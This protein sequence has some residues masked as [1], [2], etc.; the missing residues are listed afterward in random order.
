MTTLLPGATLNSFLDAESGKNPGFQENNTLTATLDPQVSPTLPPEKTILG[1]SVNTFSFVFLGIGA[2]APIIF[3]TV[4]F[5][6]MKCLSRRRLNRFKQYE[7]RMRITQEIWDL[8]R[9]QYFRSWQPRRGDIGRKVKST[10]DEI[11]FLDDS[12][13]GGY[14]YSYDQKSLGIK[15][16][17]KPLDMDNA[18]QSNSNPEVFFKEPPNIV[19][20]EKY[21]GP[22]H[23]RAFSS[24][25][26]IYATPQKANH[27]SAVSSDPPLSP[28]TDQK[29]SVRVITAVPNSP[30][31][32]SINSEEERALESFD[33]IYEDLDIDTSNENTLSDSNSL[34]RRSNT[35][36]P[37]N[38]KTSCDTGSLQAN[39]RVD[40][41]PMSNLKSHKQIVSLVQQGGG[42]HVNKNTRN[43]AHSS[44]RHQVL[45]NTLSGNLS[46]DLHG[47]GHSQCYSVS[48][49]SSTKSSVDI[50]E[51]TPLRPVHL[52]L[53]SNTFQG[54]HSAVA[55]TVTIE[56]QGRGDFHTASP[57]DLSLI[58]PSDVTIVT[59]E[60][61]HQSAMAYCNKAYLRQD[62]PTE[63]EVTKL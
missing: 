5:V 55:S 50:T 58:D 46:D 25:G 37:T 36:N 7:A 59:N 2:I 61:S 28:T 54:F 10:N 27:D 3:L 43:E 34:I 6:T 60:D 57:L 22:H 16:T 63:N 48:S 53:T 45:I 51:M 23:V 8:E 31:H 12:S 39:Q 4:V 29:E 40:N 1:L 32:H 38:G 20:M 21:R 62:T 26:E 11:D 44:D 14:Y 47:R 15:K 33:K 9:R 19:F 17:R 30:S 52:P 24:P 49:S 18:T 35:P 13:G 41:L 56:S 42:H